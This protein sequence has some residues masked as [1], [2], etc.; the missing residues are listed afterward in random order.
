MTRI[1]F[2]FLTDM[3]KHCFIVFLIEAILLVIQ[4]SYL[5]VECDYSGWSI[6][7][8]ALKHLELS[9]CL[10]FRINF[11]PWRGEVGPNLDIFDV[12]QII[13][14]SCKVVNLCESSF[15]SFWCSWR[16][17]Y[18]IFLGFN[19]IANTTNLFNQSMKLITLCFS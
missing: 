9:F 6:V 13:C 15:A 4:I 10:R 18:F 5:V 1:L 11:G 14:M 2:N 19:F 16:N 17:W 12:I 7:Y 3:A 8:F